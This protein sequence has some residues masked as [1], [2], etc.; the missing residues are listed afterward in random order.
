MVSLAEDGQ[1]MIKYADQNESSP[2]NVFSATT[3]VIS[4]GAKA[5]P[6]GVTYTAIPYT[7]GGLKSKLGCK[8]RVLV[9]FKS[10]ATDIV[11]SEESQ[12]EIPG[13]LLD[14]R[15][16]VVD[17]VILT[18]ENMTGFT[19]AGTVDVT[20]TIGLPVRLCYWDVPRGLTFVLDPNGK[21]RAYIGDDTA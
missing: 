9:Y 21:V 4:G 8:G 3:L 2:E 5:A 1:F 20:A 15:G 19:Q 13:L 18:Q 12:F 16:A 14:E 10:N 11:E 6:T 7:L 17:S